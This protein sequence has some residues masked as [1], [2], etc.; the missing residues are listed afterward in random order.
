MKSFG[1]VLA[2]LGAGLAGAGV[3]LA[4]AHFANMEI[5]W[6]AWGIGFLVGL[7]V[8]FVAYRSDIDESPTLGIYSALVAAGSIV[9]AKY[10]LYHMLVVSPGLS[11]EVPFTAMFSLFDALWFGL[12]C[13]TAFKIGVGSYGD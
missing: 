2:G 8:R 11:G 6:I 4:I 3:W 5:G 1:W 7:A 9:L 10:G 13:V 12:A